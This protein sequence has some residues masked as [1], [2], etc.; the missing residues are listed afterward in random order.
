MR[1]DNT[2]CVILW[3]HGNRLFA[4]KLGDM[5][6]SPGAP[7]QKAISV[8]PFSNFAR[9]LKG[10]RNKHIFQ[11]WLCEASTED[12]TFFLYLYRFN[13]NMSNRPARRV[14]DF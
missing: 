11:I 7:A 14:F 4:H 10:L 13:V 12:K 9:A 5:R 6:L 1:N 2:Y 3:R 8:S